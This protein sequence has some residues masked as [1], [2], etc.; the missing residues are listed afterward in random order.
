MDEVITAGEMRQLIREELERVSLEELRWIAG[1][2]HH[3]DGKRSW[4]QKIADLVLGRVSVRARTEKI[5]RE[6]LPKIDAAI[7]TGQ[8]PPGQSVEAYERAL[9]R[10][11]PDLGDV[12]GHMFMKIEDLEST[13]AELHATGA[14]AEYDERER[15]K[16]RRIIRDCLRSITQDARRLASQ[17]SRRGLRRQRK[18]SPVPNKSWL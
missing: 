13:A 18:N 15:K 16:L 11:N 1:S 8:F 2:A 17:R 6:L 14:A 7:Q 9:N 10:L 4:W 12:I 5:L 3:D